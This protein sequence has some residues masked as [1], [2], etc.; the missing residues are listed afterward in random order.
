[1]DVSK[2][3]TLCDFTKHEKEAER[4]R[5]FRGEVKP[6]CTFAVDDNWRMVSGLRSGLV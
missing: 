2:L 3:D 5:K 4:Y 6:D 1:M